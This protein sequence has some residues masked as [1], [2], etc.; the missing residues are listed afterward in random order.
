VA[1]QNG[2]MK[3]IGIRS[4]V[5]ITWDGADLIIPNGD[6]LNQHLVNWTMGSSRRRFVLQVG[7][8]YGTDLDKVVL[9]L[10]ELMLQDSR[11]LRSPEPIV[12]ASEFNN[13][14]IDMVVKFWV[15]HFSIGFDVRSDLIL[16]IDKTF[17]EHGI[18]IPFPQLD[19]H[20]DSL[21]DTPQ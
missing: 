13:S 9:L 20:T 4:S 18:V 14:S 10:N 19:I 16:T 21:A 8:A 17:R 5:V 12:W 15:S 7:V 11:I 2:R 3:S 1:G 6:L